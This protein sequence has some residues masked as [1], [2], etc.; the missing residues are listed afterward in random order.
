MNLKE[1]EQDNEELRK[2][3]GELE[4]EK[5]ELEKINCNFSDAIGEISRIINRI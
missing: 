1:L 2:R 4:D 3:I 5:M